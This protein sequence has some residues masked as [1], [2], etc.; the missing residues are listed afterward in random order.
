MCITRSDAVRQLVHNVL[1]VK[2]Q[3]LLAEAVFRI[4]TKKYQ[5]TSGKRSIIPVRDQTILQRCQLMCRK[6]ENDDDGCTL[7]ITY[8]RQNFVIL[9]L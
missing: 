3:F 5:Q 9:L 1:T 4:K 2:V 8:V 7:H 6:K